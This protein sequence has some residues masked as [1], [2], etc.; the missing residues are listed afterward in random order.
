MQC[1]KCHT[2]DI[3]IRY[4]KYGFFAA[5]N[6]FPRCN[7]NKSF[8][9]AVLQILKQE[10]VNLYGWQHECY[11]CHKQTPVYTYFINKQLKPYMEYGI[12][13]G[14]LGLDTIPSIDRYLTKKYDS[15]NRN[16]SKTRNC[17]TVSNNCIHC[18]ALVGNFYIVD[19]PHDIFDDWMTGNLDHYLVEKI[20]FSVLN[21]SK[22][23]LSGIGQ[24]FVQIG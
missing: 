5:C 2:G 11:R 14:N 17:Y 15:I 23:E 24:E 18:H 8:E 20:P 16:F 19:D 22:E 1:P 3:I 7:F 9:E 4:G 12:E 13:L 10:G 6:T 21:I